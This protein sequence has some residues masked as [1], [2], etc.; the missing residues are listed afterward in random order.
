MADIYKASSKYNIERAL[1]SGLKAGIIDEEDKEILLLYLYE[2]DANVG[3]SLPRK[4]KIIGTL[5]G[6]QHLLSLSNIDGEF[7]KRCPIKS[8]KISDIYRGLDLLRTGKNQKGTNFKQN[9]IYD[10]IV[11]GKAFWRWLIENNLADLDKEKIKKIKTPP[12]DIYTKKPSDIL[13]EEEILALIENCKY[14]RDKAFISLLY[15]TGCRIGELADLKWND[16]VF[17]QYGLKVYVT[18]FKEKG[19]RYVRCIM[20][21]SYLSAWKNEVYENPNDFIFVALRT[22]GSLD[23]QGFR[24]ILITAKKKAK[25]TKNIHPHLFRTSRITHMVAKGYQ[26]SVIKRMMWDNLSTNMFDIYVK[27]SEEDI[28][29]ELLEKAGIVRKDE[30]PDP[31]KPIICPRCGL[32]NAPTALFCSK[33][34]LQISKEIVEQAMQYDQEEI[35]NALTFYNQEKNKKEPQ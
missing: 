22:G 34:G 24:K 29:S 20:S 14:T 30:K 15:E 35:L 23:Y 7:S 21:T 18:D 17:D 27:L 12:Q 6:W 13:T 4:R 16:V 10:Y 19:R 31:L 5:L 33:C 32:Q 28:D 25:I 3:L 26:E 1:Q 9:T 2:R 8:I 11:I